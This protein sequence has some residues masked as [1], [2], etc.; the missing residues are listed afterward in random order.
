MP[1]SELK[2]QIQKLVVNFV[3][4]CSLLLMIICPAQSTMFDIVLHLSWSYGSR[5]GWNS[6]YV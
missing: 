2:I 4:N 3:P 1:G 5:N 6:E